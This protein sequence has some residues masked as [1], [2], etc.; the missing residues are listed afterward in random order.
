MISLGQIAGT[1]RLGLLHISAFWD[2]LSQEFNQHIPWY[3]RE[4]DCP[5][6]SSV[7]FNASSWNLT[8]NK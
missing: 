1:V 4:P 6:L 5:L 3:Y 2:Y 8:L 7:H